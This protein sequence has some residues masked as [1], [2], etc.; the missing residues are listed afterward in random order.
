M[1][2]EEKAAI[3]LL[4]LDEDLA[5]KVIKNLRPEEAEAIG[6]HMSRITSISMDE[7]NSVAKEFCDLARTKGGI[8]AVSDDSKKNI[9]LKGLGEDR[10]QGVLTMIKEEGK[11]GSSVVAKLRDMDPQVLSDFTKS[12]HPQTIALILSHLNSSQAAAL[13]NSLPAEMRADV[14][15]AV[16]S[17]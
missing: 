10:A 8:V 1:T 15:I 9:F 12:E 6:K 13:L 4:S 3:L 5:A 7:V 11:G 17:R 16:Q 2:S 14:E